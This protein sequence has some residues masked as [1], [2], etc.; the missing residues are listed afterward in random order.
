MPR[1]KVTLT[2]VEFI[3]LKIQTHPGQS[4]RF[5]Q[6]ALYQYRFGKL[7]GN[8]SFGHHYFG[9]HRY[10]E[11]YYTKNGSGTRDRS[12]Y[13]L[14]HWQDEAEHTI[15]YG[16]YYNRPEV[17]RQTGSSSSKPKVSKWIL[18]GPGERAANRARQKL[19]LVEV[20]D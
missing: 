13:G 9:K 8:T 11:A 16:S 10:T 14:T 1:A 7:K 19:G 17:R 18:R 12:C 4:G 20:A 3:A 15:K 6:R 2:N 5:Y